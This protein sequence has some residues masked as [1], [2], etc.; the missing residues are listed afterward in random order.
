MNIESFVFYIFYTFI[1]D[2]FSSAESIF[3][4]IETNT[5]FI[6]N[7]EFY[8]FSYQIG[9]YGAY[10]PVILVVIFGLTGA[11]LYLVF[12]LISGAQEVIP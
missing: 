12:I 8:T 4:D 2:I 6:L 3:S 10:I 7:N 9:Q 5:V 1:S 11:G